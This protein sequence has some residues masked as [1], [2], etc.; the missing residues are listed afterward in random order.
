MSTPKTIEVTPEMIERIV[1][2]ALAL[3]Y[4]TAQQTEE[5]ARFFRRSA[6]RH[7]LEL[8]RMLRMAVHR[9]EEINAQIRALVNTD[10]ALGLIASA[11][12]DPVR[13]AVATMEGEP[14]AE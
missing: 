5:M 11:W 3:H 10:A 8:G 12:D 13:I 9:D 2:F 7:N 1:A 14:C 6:E 4:A